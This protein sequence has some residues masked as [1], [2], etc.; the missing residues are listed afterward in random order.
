VKRPRTPAGTQLPPDPIR[1]SSGTPQ[2]RMLA[3]RRHLARPT[4]PM[5]AHIGAPTHSSNN[6]VPTLAAGNDHEY[7]PAGREMRGAAEA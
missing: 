2:A 7:G 4:S 6:R 3:L 1:I 5:T